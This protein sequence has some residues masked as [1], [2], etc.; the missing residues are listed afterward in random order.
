MKTKLMI[1]LNDFTELKSGMTGSQVNQNAAINDLKGI[2]KN[3][4]FS[5]IATTDGK[6]S[7]YL[8]FDET[9]DEIR[10]KEI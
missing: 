9:I 4:D 6:P 2:I 10:L 3:N 1:E 8:I 7:H 5:V